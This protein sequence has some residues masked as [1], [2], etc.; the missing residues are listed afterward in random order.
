[1]LDPGGIERLRRSLLLPVSRRLALNRGL[2][3]A[4]IVRWIA[5][6]RR[7]ESLLAVTLLRVLLRV[8]CLLT[9]GWGSVLLRRR[10]VARLAVAGRWIRS[11]LYIRIGRRPS[12]G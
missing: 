12:L 7:R 6:R 8:R 5:W 11:L 1:M 2:T 3:L 9:I 10:C 4:V